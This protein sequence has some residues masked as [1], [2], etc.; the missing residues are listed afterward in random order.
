[1][2]YRKVMVW[3]RF[4]EA[5]NRAGFPSYAFAVLQKGLCNNDEW[6]PSTETDYAPKD[7]LMEYVID[8][9]VIAS[10]TIL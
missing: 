9:N 6:Y 3:L 4:A 1:M 5:I 8:G 2:V 7:Y 10:D